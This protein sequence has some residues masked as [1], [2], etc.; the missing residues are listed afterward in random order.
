MFQTNMWCYLWDLVDE[1]ID[2]V[3][4]RLQDGYF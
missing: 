1:G 2:E 4:N 3:L